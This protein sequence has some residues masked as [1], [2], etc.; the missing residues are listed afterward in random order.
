MPAITQTSANLMQTVTLERLRSAAP[1]KVTQIDLAKA[2]DCNK[3]TV[4]A[5]E[6]GKN[7]DGIGYRDMLLM[8]ELFN[9]RL[10]EVI[11]AIANTHALTEE[12]PTNL[13]KPN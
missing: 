1:R 2:L 7:L 5:W 3:S 10:E 6:N 11:A 9:C 8:A 4:S 13:F 12:E